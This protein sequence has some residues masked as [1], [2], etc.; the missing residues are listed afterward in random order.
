MM[1]FAR[2]ALAAFLTFAGLASLAMPD[3]QAIERQVMEGG[4]PWCE[5][6]ASL[7]PYLVAVLSGDKAALAAISNCEILTGGTVLDVLSQEGDLRGYSVARASLSRGG[8]TRTG[9]T[10]SGL[11]EAIHKPDGGSKA[12]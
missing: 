10:M 11:V 2:T 5:E 3:A 12:R 8:Q 9:F 6:R 7:E 4:A 1:R